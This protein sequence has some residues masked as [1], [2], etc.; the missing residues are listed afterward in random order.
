MELNNS[1]SDSEWPESSY[2][3]HERDISNRITQTS[4][5]LTK[6]RPFSQFDVEFTVSQGSAKWF[7]NDAMIQEIRDEWKR[8]SWF[9][10]CPPKELELLERQKAAKLI[11]LIGQQLSAYFYFLKIQFLSRLNN[12]LFFTN[13]P[14]DCIINSI[15]FMH[16]FYIFHPIQ[17]FPCKVTALAALS[18]GTK[19]ENQRISCQSIV[20]A[21]MR[22][23]KKEFPEKH[24]KSFLQE[25][26]DTEKFMTLTLGC[27]L[28]VQHPF[29]YISDA[30]KLFNCK[31]T[32]DNFI[33]VIHSIAYNR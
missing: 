25:I 32:S 5:E 16:R 8:S 19:S 4:G 3:M 18:L 6:I 9:T 21:M 20:K 14:F 29:I 7:V 12:Q 2:T 17:M 24:L 1:G 13:R 33:N 30:C 22:A 28:D 15:V 23:L 11:Q 31:D 10:A 26:I 27:D